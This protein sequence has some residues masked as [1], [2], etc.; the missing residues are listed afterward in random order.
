[1]KRKINYFL[2]ITLVLLLTACSSKNGTVQKTTDDSKNQETIISNSIESYLGKTVGELSKELGE[3]CEISYIG[4]E[5]KPSQ[6]SFKY[7]KDSLLYGIFFVDDLKESLYH[8]NQFYLESITTTLPTNNVAN[9]L[10]DDDVNTVK[11]KLEEAKIDYKVSGDDSIMYEHNNYRYDIHLASG[12]ASQITCSIHFNG[13]KKFENYC[14]EIPGGSYLENGDYAVTTDKGLLHIYKDATGYQ[15]YDDIPNGTLTQVRNKLI[16]ESNDGNTKYIIDSSRRRGAEADISKEDL[17]VLE[18]GKSNVE[19][20][21]VPVKTKEGKTADYMYSVYDK[22]YVEIVKY[23]GDGVAN[24]V[25]PGKIEGLPVT[26]IGEDSFNDSFYI[27]KV[28]ESITLPGSIVSIGDNAFSHD[29]LKSIN[30]PNGVTYIGEDVFSYTQISNIKIPDSVT[31]IGGN[32][33]L[34]TPYLENCKDEFVIVG[35][36][37]LIQYKGNSENV[38][39]PRGVKLIGGESFQKNANIKHVIIPEGVTRIGMGAFYNSGISTVEI[40]ESVLEIDASAFK[41]SS[42]TQIKIPGSVKSLNY[43]VLSQCKKLTKVELPNRLETIGDQAF[44][45]CRALTNITIPNGV[46]KI[47]DGAFAY[48]DNLSKLII[49][50]SVSNIGIRAIGKNTTIIAPENSYAKAYADENNLKYSK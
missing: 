10:K 7:E 26:H 13:K 23:I 29:N 24:V 41:E 47:A 34:H 35:D 2:I 45:G 15:L 30:I 16:Y 33:F 9:I 42:L 48:C 6:A 39:I 3:N 5:K 43:G 20:K 46:S 40:P 22:Q 18:Q 36:G 44:N 4:D 21:H 19:P 17:A 37:L 49:P 27:S 8:N 11:K 50:S 38:V 28:I 14:K 1:M 25:V 32:A 31:Y 12:K